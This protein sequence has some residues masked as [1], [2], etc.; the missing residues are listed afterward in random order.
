MR[1]WN[2]VFNKGPL[3]GD[4]SYYVVYNLCTDFLPDFINLQYRESVWR[5]TSKRYV[6]LPLCWGKSGYIHYLVLVS[7]TVGYGICTD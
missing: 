3:L 5:F 1:V 4:I 6:L 7:C 2:N